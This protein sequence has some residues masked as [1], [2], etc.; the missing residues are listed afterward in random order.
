MKKLSRILVL[1][2]LL[3]PFIVRADV[4]GPMLTSYE[5][6]INNQNGAVEYSYDYKTNT[7]SASTAYLEKGKVIEIY[8]E[9]YFDGELYLSY[10][11]ERYDD[12]F[13]IKKSDV[14][15]NGEDLIEPGLNYIG[16]DYLYAIEDLELLKGPGQIYDKAN[17]GFVP[18]GSTMKILAGDEAYWYVEY[19]GNR[20]WVLEEST[21]G[22]VSPVA[23]EREDTYTNL[24]KKVTLFN[25]PNDSAGTTVDIEIGTKF[26][27]KYEYGNGWY[28]VE[29]NGELKWI[30]ESDTIV[31]DSQQKAIVFDSL[32][33]YS[34]PTCKIKV[35]TLNRFEEYEITSYDYSDE[36]D[37]NAEIIK[38]VIRIDGKI[39]YLKP[40]TYGQLYYV[41]EC[42]YLIPFSK[43]YYT[44]DIEGKE[45]VK[46]FDAFSRIKVKGTI[47][48]VS[49]DMRIFIIEVDGEY[50]YYH[51]N[52]LKFA[53]YEYN[54]RQ[55]LAPRMLTAKK[56]M[57]IIIDDKSE[58]IKNGDEYLYIGQVFYDGKV[59]PRYYVKYKDR[60]GVVA[61]DD[62]DFYLSDK[63]NYCL[64]DP[65]QAITPEKKTT[66]EDKKNNN[67]N[68]I[69][70][71]SIVG[72]CVAL[73]GIVLIIL[74]NKKKKAKKATEDVVDNKDKKEE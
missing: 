29:Y 57:Y 53:Y 72:G 70:I 49:A 64:D 44:K 47:Y 67:H 6:I 51:T 60:Y 66:T 2:I 69:I 21:N 1:I 52:A 7:I 37:E 26:K 12:N 25:N 23:F 31:Y 54:S 10:W 62:V 8:D 48:N 55:S 14:L 34:D 39:Y 15:I 24:T 32:D 40:S 11:D 19:N 9:R 56:D 58:Q 59:E 43:R 42:G 17:N 73:T 3:L 13:Y 20:G 16:D 61:H 36:E 35:G 38:I 5:V 68:I 41:P 74:I 27:S 50:Y 46:E 22:I 63:L 65:S 30:K 28:G 18:K 4:G 45:V 33:Y 71:S